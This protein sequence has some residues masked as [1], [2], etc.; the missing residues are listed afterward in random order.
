VTFI[1]NGADWRFD[2]EARTAVAD[3]LE[4]FFDFAGTS[5]ERGET[6]SFG[7]DFQTRPVL[8][9][10]TLWDL[11]GPDAGLHLPGEMRQELAAWLLSPHLYADDDW[12]DGADEVEVGIAD[13]APTANADVAWAHH[14]V[15][16]GRS[17]ACFALREDAV[18]NTVTDAGGAVLH[19]V[20][21]EAGRRRFWR[22]AIVLEGDS[23]D[24]LRRNAAHAY[25]D[26]LFVEG[27]LANLEGLT[28]GYLAL[29]GRVRAALAV[30]DDDGH[31]IFTCPPPVA[32]RREDP[33][34][35]SATL[36][37]NHLIR[38]RFSH[39]GLDVAPENPDVQAHRRSREA[40]ETTLMG[41]TLYCEWHIKLEPHRNRVHLHRPVQESGDKVVVAMIHEHLPLPG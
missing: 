12:P 25:P 3:A 26:V 29:R 24:S 17:V 33:P 37:P 21:T 8:G 15:R 1:V 19:F 9:T 36:P 41:R 14:C 5:R 4:R 6:M 20:A 23:A 13:S 40:R 7:D 31:W 38:V 2:G 35:P 34:P 22:E 27:V 28:G 11:F 18:V 39:Y 16:A 30:L 32:T 10:L